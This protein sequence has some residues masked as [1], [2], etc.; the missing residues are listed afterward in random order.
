MI[1]QKIQGCERD[2]EKA[3]LGGGAILL[4]VRALSLF[5]LFIFLVRAFFFFFFFSARFLGVKT[6]NAH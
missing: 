2:S 1:D 4:C 5:F 6:E 3:Y